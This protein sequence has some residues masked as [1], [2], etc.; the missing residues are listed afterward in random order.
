M[1][2]DVHYNVSNNNNKKKKSIAKNLNIASF[3]NVL[4]FTCL[5]CFSFCRPRS[6][7]VCGKTHQYANDAINLL[8]GLEEVVLKLKARVCI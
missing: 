8:L 6:R 1:C 5:L 2:N 7:V 4:S 3:I